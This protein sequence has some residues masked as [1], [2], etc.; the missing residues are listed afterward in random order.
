MIPDVV[1]PAKMPDE[2]MLS[3]KTVRQNTPNGDLMTT[4]EIEFKAPRN[5]IPLPEPGPAPP[6]I[7]PK[8]RPSK[9]RKKKRK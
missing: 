1:P 2:E 4:L 8:Q 3:L 7:V 9:K 5:Y 6:I